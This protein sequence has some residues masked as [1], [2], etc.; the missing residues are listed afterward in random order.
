MRVMSLVRY[1]VVGKC[2]IVIH[3]EDSIKLDI[4]SV[5]AMHAIAS[6][7]KPDDFLECLCSLSLCHI[8]CIGKP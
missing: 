1:Y 6:C 3:S 5:L 2:I 4:T 8:H 7:G